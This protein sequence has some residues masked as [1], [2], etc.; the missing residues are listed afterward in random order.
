MDKKTVLKGA[1][2]GLSF[3]AVVPVGFTLGINLGD[4]IGKRIVKN[5][6]SSVAG[7]KSIEADAKEFN[8]IAKQLKSRWLTKKQK[9]ELTLKLKVIQ[10]ASPDLGEA[11]FFIFLDTGINTGVSV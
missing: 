7:D 1:V 6:N 4:N 3:A 8:A 9:T 10:L 5:V 2:Y 11:I